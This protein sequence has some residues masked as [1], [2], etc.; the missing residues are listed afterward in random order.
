MKFWAYALAM[1]LAMAGL[2][3]EAAKRANEF[4]CAKGVTDA[5]P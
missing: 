4:A 2:D 3:A 1:V 5:C